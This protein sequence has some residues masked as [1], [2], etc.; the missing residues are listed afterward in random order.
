MTRST[1]DKIKLLLSRNGFVIYM[2][3]NL[4]ILSFLFF[5]DLL[6]CHEDIQMNIE[7]SSPKNQAINQQFR[8]IFVNCLYFNLGLLHY[9]GHFIQFQSSHSDVYIN[10]W[11]TKSSV[12][13]SILKLDLYMNYLCDRENAC[14]ILVCAQKMNFLSIP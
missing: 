2:S 13:G 11:L 7:I 6:T 14:Y 4:Y 9:I 5:F 12:I 1:N 10:M 3:Q 8:C